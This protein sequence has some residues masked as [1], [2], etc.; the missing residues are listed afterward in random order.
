MAENIATCTADGKIL[1]ENYHDLVQNVHEENC[2][3]FGW[4]FTPLRPGAYGYDNLVYAIHDTFNFLEKEKDSKD[5]KNP[6]NIAEIIHQ[7]WIK[8][9][10]FWR[11]NTPYEKSE[12]YKKPYNP[13]NDERRNK[14]ASTP[15]ASLDEDE[16]TKDIVLAKIIQK[17]WESMV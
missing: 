6:E 1:Y 12:K 3:F 15:F 13:I 17:K 10:V 5:E 7:S 14:C 2:K 11:D 8:N 16:R 4:K 9:Y